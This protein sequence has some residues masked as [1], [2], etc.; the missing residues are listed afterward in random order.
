M[1]RSPMVRQVRHDLN[2][3]P[4]IAIWEV[5]RACQ[6]ICR[7]CR[8]DAQHEPAPGQLS[9]GE[10]FALLDSLASYEHPRPLVVL[11]GGDP[12]ERGD[13]AELTRYGT[14][15]GLNISLSPSVTPRLTREKLE[16]MRAAGG[17]A[18]SLSLDGAEAAT[19]DHFR[20]F[21]GTFDQTVRMA[22]VVTD[23][24]FRL[25]INSTLTA[26]NVREAPA[27]LAR[28]IDLGA[29]LWSVFFLVPTGRGAGLGA[30]SADERED[31]L[32]WLHDVSDRVAVKTTEA[33]QYRRVVLQ[34]AQGQAYEG[35]ELYRYL[36]SETALLLGDRPANPRQPRPPM[37]VNAG[38][39][40][41][42]ID[43]LGD[44][45]PNGFLP[46]RCGNVKDSPL[47]EIYSD[48]PVFRSLRD[49]STWK[50]KCSVC[51]FA[52]VCGGSRSTAYAVTGDPLASD[53][54][55]SYVP[56]ARRF[57]ERAGQPV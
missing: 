47:P 11:T 55:C 18:L 42:F 12:F 9:T 28:V 22:Q 16:D 27:M 7:H 34:R 10:G 46:L 39:G 54:T 29:R 26:G 1:T 4:F 37:A 2:V 17:S 15:L 38:S 56:D 49:P 43:H 36:T 44:V 53:P 21:A 41:V 40:F 6:L 57:P 14:D 25:Q 19:H 30:L 33:P 52:A 50:G 20:G 8:A 24:G 35:G 32:H 45:Y 51:E 13:L 3:K 23:V 5:T 31:V 48:S